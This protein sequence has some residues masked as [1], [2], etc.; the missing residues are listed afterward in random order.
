MSFDL[1]APHYRWMEVVLAGDKLQ[2]CRVHW[3]DAVRHCRRA[4]LVGEGNGRFLTACVKRLPDTSFTIVDA[5]KSMLQQAEA[6]WK[7]AGGSSNQVQF[8]H[9]SFPGVKL[10]S[11]HFD[12]I[13]TNCFFDCF[14]REQLAEVIANIAPAA[15][16]SAIWLVT[17]FAVPAR[18]WAK[19]RAKLVLWAAYRFFRL[20]TK[21]PAHG[22]CPPDSFLIGAG[23]ELSG[24]IETDAGLLYSAMWQRSKNP[25]HAMH[26]AAR[27]RD[28]T[29]T[30][31]ALPIVS[32]ALPT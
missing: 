1:L 31:R 22:I 18:G 7:K 6:N 25:N 13:V 11:N 9:A 32:A 12:L 29:S 20:T 8:V 16:P 5:S 10:P 28:N 30:K 19:W 15:S 21:I 27:H 14:G 26:T 2:R 23:F 3:L 4:L 24:R 17:D